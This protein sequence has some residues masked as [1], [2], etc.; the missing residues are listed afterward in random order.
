MVSIVKSSEVPADIKF[1]N[2]LTSLLFV[3]F[4]FL[5]TFSGFQYVIKNKI[6]NLDAITI[7]GDVLHN[8]NI[9]ISDNISNKIYGNFYN[10]DLKKTKQVFESTPWVSHA[11]VKR[12]YPSQVEVTLSEYK[13]K[14]IWG[15]REDMKLIDDTGKI[16]DVG[17]DED[18]YESLPQLIGPEGQGK[19]M[20]NMYKEVSSALHPIKGTLR[21]LE[22]N[23]RGSWIATL[24]GGAHI[25]LG[26]GNTVDAI[27]RV[28]KFS[29]SVEKMLTKFNK[30]L[31]DIQYVDLRHSDGYA[32]RMHGVS[33]LDSTLTTASFKK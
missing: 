14:A 27:D 31:L 6:K 25:E 13:S 3:L 17:A 21:N 22:L 23:A 9:S 29:L 32:M 7:R 20:L 12:V 33:T 10:I 18:E 1:V 2:G 5:L 4:I 16:F 19:L 15:A 28:V 11:V 26:R 24:D 8:D 30:K